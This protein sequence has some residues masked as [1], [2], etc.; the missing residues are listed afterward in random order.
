M[1]VNVGLHVEDQGFALER[2]IKSEEIILVR[3]K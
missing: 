3:N 2:G 1:L